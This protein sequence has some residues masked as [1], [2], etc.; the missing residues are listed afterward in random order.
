MA[1]ETVKDVAFVVAQ[2]RVALCPALMLVVLALKFRVG[3]GFDGGVGVEEPPLHPTKIISSTAANA[4]NAIDKVRNF[5]V[6]T[7]SCG[8]LM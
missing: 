6:G 2:V 5:M 8:K 3:A 1:G 4:T 7:P